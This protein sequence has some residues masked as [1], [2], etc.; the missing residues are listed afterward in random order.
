MSRQTYGGVLK[1]V[2]QQNGQVGLDVLDTERLGPHLK[3]LSSLRTPLLK[4]AAVALPALWVRGAFWRVQLTA[5]RHLHVEACR[6]AESYK[7]EGAQNRQPTPE[8]EPL[9]LAQALDYAERTWP[10]ALRNDTSLSAALFTLC[11][12]ATLGGAAIVKHC[13]AVFSADILQF[14]Q[15]DPEILSD[16]LGKHVV[17][18]AELPLKQQEWLGD[19]TTQFYHCLR[20]GRALLPTRCSGCN[21][22]Y[23]KPQQFPERAMPLPLPIKRA[24]GRAGIRFSPVGRWVV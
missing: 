2:A 3:G 21:V 1:R 10:H 23:A 13:S 6:T 19:G 18:T 22:Q 17:G 24:W 14:P 20:C 8:P 11:D 7:G 4:G 5:E 15:D 9:F 16:L 12:P